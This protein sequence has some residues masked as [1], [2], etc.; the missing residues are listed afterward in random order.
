MHYLSGFEQSQTRLDQRFHDA[1][2]IQS[3]YAELPFAAGAA[4]AEVLQDAAFDVIVEIRPAE[5]G[6]GLRVGERE[7]LSVQGGILDMVISY[8]GS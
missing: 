7:I 4:G 6:D 1:T 3:H 2:F 8:Q 5:G